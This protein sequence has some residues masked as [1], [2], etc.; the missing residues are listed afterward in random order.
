MQA[1]TKLSVAFWLLISCSFAALG[2]AP[3]QQQQVKTLAGQS[4]RT[5]RLAYLLYE[6]ADYGKDPSMSWPLLVYL[7][8][9]SLRGD[10][11]GRLRGIGLP[12]RLET[13]ADFPCIVVSPQCAAGEIWTD[14]D[15]MAALLD[16][17]THEYRV[18]ASRV[19]LMGHSMGGRGA[20][21]FAYRMPE[22]FAAVFAVSPISPVDAWAQRLATVPLW[23]VHGS[24][25]TIAP[26]AE[27]ASMIRC[28][29]MAGGHPRFEVLAGRDHFLL[30]ECERP[31]VL[32]WLLA[33]HR[34]ATR[35]LGKVPR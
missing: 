8:G 26:V 16:E 32:E 20:L 34:G 17:V 7:H 3:Q 1:N 23:V 27:A 6:P 25:D 18:D 12:H 14:A 33:Q 4:T 31:D 22:Q 13:R 24:T 19:Y 9:G 30:D 11:A 28:I 15:A 10:E 2:A 29:E 5:I 35:T 21:Y